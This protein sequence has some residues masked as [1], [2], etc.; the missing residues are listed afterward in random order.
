VAGVRST[1]GT[2]AKFWAVRLTARLDGISL[3][4]VAACLQRSNHYKHCVDIG[5]E[6][7][8]KETKSTSCGR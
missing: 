6:A 5:R 7:K 4:L 1:E 8:L 3:R 2:Q